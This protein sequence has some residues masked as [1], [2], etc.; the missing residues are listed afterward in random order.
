M[1]STNHA[2]SSIEQGIEALADGQVIIVV[3][4]EEREDEGDFLVAAELVTPAAIHFMISQGRGQLCM[5]VMPETAARLALRPM[6]TESGAAGDQPRF[7]V[8]IDHRACRSGI[9]PLE[10]VFTI[11]AMIDR[12][13]RPDDFVRPG[14]IFPLIAQ[15]GGVLSRA[16]HTE[17]SVDLARYAGLSP[18]GVL[19]EICSSD[20]QNMAGRAELFSIAQQ[21][22]LHVI[23]IDDLIEYRRR[24][25]SGR[26]WN[27]AAPPEY[28]ALGIVL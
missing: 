7:A 28:R 25:V 19:C 8:P 11:Q 3:D 24:H 10:R 12:N 15:P 14:H 26:Q 4:S 1:S 22:G 5:P 20:G 2:F 17:A 9:S 18:A 27:S 13:S 6:V 16:G 21:F 23:T